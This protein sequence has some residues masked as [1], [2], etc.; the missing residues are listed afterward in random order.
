[1]IRVDKI[2]KR[3]KDFKLDIDKLIIEPGNYVVILGD[4]GS[5]KSML[6]EILAGLI[7]PDQGLISYD[8]DELT[9]KSI[10]ERPFGLVFQDQALFPHM[11][12]RQNIAFPLK[13]LLKKKEDVKIRTLE[14]AKNMEASHLL[15]RYPD[16][17]SGGER[18][19]VALART[20]AT[21]P[22]CLL[23]DEPL[24]SLDVNLKKEIRALLRWL[25][26]NGQT[27][28]HVTHDYEEAIS[29]ASHIGVMD[30]GKLIQFGN[31]EKVLREPRS[32]FI[33]NFTG[34]RN[35]FKV[36]LEPNSSTGEAIART[37]S[38]SDIRMS[39]EK[40]SGHG[41]VIIPC[42]SIVL[43]HSKIE[44][45]ASNQFHGIIN[46]ITPAR[47]GIEVKVDAEI[48]LVAQVT[49]STIEKLN[50]SEGQSIWLNFKATSVRF[51]KK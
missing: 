5:G 11:T 40:S 39:T 17:L 12:A 46:E 22:S 35:Y 1:M 15:D 34:I 8:G 18:Q 2:I 3:F 47:H 21:Q 28:L 14:L 27:I 4:S 41:F 37:E 25:N 45:S 7:S 10:Q 30:K 23:L 31:A 29:L 44:S 51:I 20:L 42:D 32:S 16:T 36:N 43:S 9:K 49:Q 33:A 38:G 50:L 26:R 19:R 48:Q 13:K 24:S 6:L